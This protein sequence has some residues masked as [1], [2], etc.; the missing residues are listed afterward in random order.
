MQKCSS[1]VIDKCIEFGAP[2]N[3]KLIVDELINC[4][5]LNNLIMNSYGNF[6]LV[7]SLKFAQDEQRELLIAQIEKHLPSISDLKLKQKWAVVIKKVRTG[8][9]IKDIRF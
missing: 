3:V 2:E 9:S 1:N 8:Q 6:V 4:E 7:N 5:R